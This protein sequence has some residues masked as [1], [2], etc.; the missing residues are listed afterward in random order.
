MNATTYIGYTAEDLNEMY[1]EAKA[2][3]LACMYAGDKHSTKKWKQIAIDCAV[4]LH[5]MQGGNEL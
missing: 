5:A 4:T 2:M 1:M 3:M